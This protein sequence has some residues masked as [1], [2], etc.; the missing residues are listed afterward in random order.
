MAGLLLAVGAPISQSH[1]QIINL[2]D[3][4]SLAQV[5]V[6]T[7]AGMFHWQ[8]DGQNQLVQQWFWYRV[9]GGPNLEQP[10][11]AISAPTFFTPDARTLYT[12]YNNGA[13]GVEIDYLL[14]GFSIGSGISDIQETITITNATASPL[15]MHFFQYSDF[16]L[17]DPGNDTIKLGKNIRGLFNEATQS[18]PLVALTET[19]VTPGANHGEAAF[20]NQ[21]LTKLSDGNPDNLNDNLGPVGPG[22]V[23][24]ALQW[25]M[26]IP[27]FSSKGISKDKYL[28]ILNIPE[29][30]T[31]VLAAL[32]VVGLV[33]RKRR[34]F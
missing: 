29:P 7:S 13:Y 2:V 30:S 9:D 20:F 8:A 23:T 4:N 18:D 33:L 28:H 31:F 24:W 21:T 12:S 5:D 34:S 32:G 10:I 22:D 11:N 19:V 17:G 3:N 14:T 15:T 27:A 6:G 25:D 16:D 1:G 26:T